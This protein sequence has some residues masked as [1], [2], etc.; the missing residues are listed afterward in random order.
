MYYSQPATTDP[1]SHAY[2]LILSAFGLLVLLTMLSAQGICLGQS[3]PDLVV[4]TEDWSRRDVTIA[5][6]LPRQSEPCR[7]NVRVHNKG[8]VPAQNVR[9][10]L[11]VEQPSVPDPWTAERRVDLVPGQSS[12]VEMIQ[13]KPGHNGI[14][15]VS[16]TVDP[17]DAVRETDETNNTATQAFPVVRRNLFIFNHAGERK[18]LMKL[19]NQTHITCDGN[20]AAEERAYWTRCGLSLL[21]HL[22]GTPTPRGIATIEQR[23]AYWAESGQDVA[24]N[25]LMNH[26]KGK[27][28]L[29]MA[30][31]VKAF[32][33]KYPHIWLALWCS[34]APLE[35]YQQ[36]V[37]YADAVVPEVYLRHE[38]QYKDI[39]WYLAADRKGGYADRSFISLAIDSRQGKDRD[40]RKCPRWSSDRAEIERQIRSL[41]TARPD[42]MGVALYANYAEEDLIAE[43]DDLIGR[44]WVMPV[45]TLEPASGSGTLTLRNIGA[46]DARNVVLVGKGASGDWQKKISVLEAG[47]SLDLPVRGDVRTVRIEPAPA[48]TL[49]NDKLTLAD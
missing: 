17:E 10:K 37:R 40:G 35:A 5:P 36:G 12:I 22:G 26:R 27:E 31:A 46:M 39:D 8:V 9:L 23:V 7:I 24:I 14:H 11:V 47:T 20:T 43:A 4:S 1:G 29:L 45:L 28:D 33:E 42:M 13:F 6:A 2:K 21:L 38:G 30:Q 3:L 34:P 15:K 41:R 48:L 19:R 32:K 44:Y 18:K 25:E 16:V 49:L